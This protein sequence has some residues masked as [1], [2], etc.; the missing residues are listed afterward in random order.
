LYWKR[1]TTFGAYLAFIFGA[2]FPVAFV[3]ED[4]LMQPP[5]GETAGFVSQLLSPN[6][7]GVLSFALGFAGMGLGSLLPFGHSKDQ[8]PA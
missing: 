5:A 6:M 7:R 4:M 8:K 1:A 2:I 3:L